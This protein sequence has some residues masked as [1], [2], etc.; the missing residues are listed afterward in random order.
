[1]E[2]MTFFQNILRFFDT[3]MEKPHLFGWFHI[4]CLVL[5]FGATWFLCR[6]RPKAEERFLR[7]LLLGSSILVMLFEIYKQINFSFGYES[8]ITFSYQWYSFP[9]QFCSTPMYLCFLA[10]I[11]KNKR[12]H[13]ALCA[14]LATFSLF[15]GLLVV[16][17]PVTV[18]VD[19]VGV[20]IQTMVC[21]GQMLLVGIYLIFTGY[22]K[23]DLRTVLEGSYVFAA[24]LACAMVMNGIVYNFFLPQGQV[25]NMFFI[26]PNFFP[27]V[28]VFDF[29][30][31]NTPYPL[32]FII[33]VLLFVVAATVSLFAVGGLTKLIGKKK[34]I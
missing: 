4:T 33:Y 30:Y 5:L 9:F 11:I 8:E 14:Y 21:H 23:T 3:R 10:A 13:D 22:V 20:N 16:F 6:R 32:F 28:P 17:F 18:Y 27:N 2:N 1:M 12:V 15:A 7:R 19:I 31:E 24:C 26:S 29:F 25:F 34:N